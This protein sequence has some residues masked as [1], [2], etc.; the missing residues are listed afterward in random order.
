MH[1][2]PELQIHLFSAEVMKLLGE[3]SEVCKGVSKIYASFGCIKSKKTSG[4]GIL[5][6]DIVANYLRLV[7]A[8]KCPP[9]RNITSPK[10]KG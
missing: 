10:F 5:C 3:S 1:G 8:P 9:W 4:V 2:P 6:L 7:S